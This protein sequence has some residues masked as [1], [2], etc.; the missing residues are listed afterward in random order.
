M[1]FDG[2]HVFRYSSR[3]GTPASRMRYQVSNRDKKARSAR[4]LALSE[5]MES[6]FAAQLQGSSQSVLWEQVVGATP[7]GFINVGYSDNYMRVRA[8]H[9]RD[10]SNV[11]TAT[12]LGTYSGGEIH[13]TVEEA[14][15][16]KAEIVPEHAAIAIG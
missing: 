11:I 12:K 9:P 14:L 2:L 8:E 1:R 6:R 13:G 4:L 5:A 7:N 16:A 3:P 15:S 10:L